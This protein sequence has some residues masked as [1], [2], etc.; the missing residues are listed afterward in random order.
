MSDLI[1]AS[2]LALKRPS[3]LNDMLAFKNEHFGK[4]EKDVEIPTNAF[5]GDDNKLIYD[6]GLDAKRTQNA[7][8]E[9]LKNMQA[10]GTLSKSFRGQLLQSN[11]F[12]VFKK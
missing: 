9:D 10:S 3:T 12:S 2:L 1:E 4:N 8:S 7:S 6:L 5:D 11:L